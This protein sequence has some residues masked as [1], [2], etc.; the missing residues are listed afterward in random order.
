M[1]ELLAGRDPEPLVA[2]RPA[3]VLVET[4]SWDDP[5]PGLSPLAFALRGLSARVSARLGG[6]G[7]AAQGLLLTIEHDA[8]DARFR[9]A[10]AGS[11]P[12]P[13]RGD[14]TSLGGNE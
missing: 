14:A 2:F 7:Q 11:K 12:P 1:L 10:F 9:G 4:M 6:R 8:I 13:T 5:V 3:K